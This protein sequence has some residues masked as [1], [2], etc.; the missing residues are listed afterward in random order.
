VGIVEDAHPNLLLHGQTFSSGFVIMS[1]DPAVSL[2]AASLTFSILSFITI[3]IGLLFLVFPGWLETIKSAT[4]RF[5]GSSSS[6]GLLDGLK[7]FAVL[8]GALAPDIVLLIGF[9]S[10]LMNMK[11]RYSVTSLIGILAIVV[12]WGLGSIF[13][14]SGSNAPTIIQQVTQA[15]SDAASAIAPGPSAPNVSPGNP[16]NL[17]SSQIL[18]VGAAPNTVLGSLGKKLDKAKNDAEFAQARANALEQSSKSSVGTPSTIDLSDTM[19]EAQA[20]K[21]RSAAK[22]SAEKT[23]KM[24]ANKLVGGTQLPSMIADKFNP[25]AIRGLGMF[26]VKGSP[27]G[28]AA[29]SAVFAV[30]FLDMTAGKKRTTTQVGG[31]LGFSTLALLFNIYAYREFGCFQDPSVLGILKSAALP[32][33]TGFT[34]GGIGYSVLNSK[35]VDF[36]PLDG[37]VLD[38]GGSS[39]VSSSEHKPSCSAPNDDDQ[40]VC[41]AY[42][43]GKRITSVGLH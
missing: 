26:D 36:L 4:G 39:T 11:F 23:S 29:L 35:Y 6:G 10:D 1:G 28:L 42:Q 12:H 19:S 32:L 15:A 9:I 17:S 25:C 38:T 5:T 14:G 30:Y 43:D 40:M 3:V 31:Y 7:V 34:I 8:G 2:A 37:Q 13:F 21:T 16:T 20:R 33:V 24:A 22:K 18:G 27:M 41:E